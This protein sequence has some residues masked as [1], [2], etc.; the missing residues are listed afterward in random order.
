MVSITTKRLPCQL[1]CRYKRQ[2]SGEQERWMPGHANLPNAGC[3]HGKWIPEL[4]Q[5]ALERHRE[6]VASAQHIKRTIAQVHTL[7]GF[8]AVRQT[9]P[10]TPSPP[11]QQLGSMQV[12]HATEAVHAYNTRGKSAQGS[13]Q[14]PT[15]RPTI[16]TNPVPGCVALLGSGVDLIHNPTQRIYQARNIQMQMVVAAKLV[17]KT[18]PAP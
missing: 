7:S 4:S 10:R 17:C 16:P 14:Q 1:T 12:V 5:T 2:F 3:Q 9:R 8:D 6:A 13:T 15:Y 18:Y 11:Q